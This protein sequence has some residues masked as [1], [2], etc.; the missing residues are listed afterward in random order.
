MTFRTTI[1]KKLVDTHGK[2][3]TFKSVTQ[4]TYNVS[5]GSVTNTSTDA[6]V[7]VFF[8]SYHVSEMNGTII[9]EGD[10]KAVVNTLDTSGNPI[11]EPKTGDT[12]VGQGDTVRIE[13]VQK[14][15]SGTTIACYV[16]QVRE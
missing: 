4:G 8:G 12:F 9:Q 5:T 16:C 1:L 13:N 14:I 2:A 10:R 7:K 6:T 11:V 15:F 3:V